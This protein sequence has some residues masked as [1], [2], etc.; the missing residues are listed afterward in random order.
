MLFCCILSAICT[1]LAVKKM[2]IGHGAGHLG[3][4]VC[5]VLNRSV[6]SENIDSLVPYF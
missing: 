5:H 4:A 1:G 3:A 6:W 2:Q